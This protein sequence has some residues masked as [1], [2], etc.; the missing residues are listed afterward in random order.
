VPGLEN[1]FS[2]CWQSARC[3]HKSLAVL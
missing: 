3:L 1:K 2:C